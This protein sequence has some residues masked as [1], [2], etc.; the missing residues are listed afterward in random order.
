M[1]VM[2]EIDLDQDGIIGINDW[3][4]YWEMVRLAGYK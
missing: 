1:I 2:R 4:G 3:L